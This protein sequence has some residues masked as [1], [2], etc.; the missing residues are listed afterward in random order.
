MLGKVD[1][2]EYIMFSCHFCVFRIKL[3]FYVE[4]QLCFASLQGIE[5]SVTSW[6][7]EKLIIYF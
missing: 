2:T 7:L 4:R 3:S 5:D 6:E 1:S